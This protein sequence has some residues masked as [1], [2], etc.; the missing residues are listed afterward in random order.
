[1]AKRVGLGRTRSRSTDGPSEAASPGADMPVTDDV[2]GELQKSS[3][4]SSNPGRI[5]SSI[6]SPA[7]GLGGQ[8]ADAKV[9]GD[10][11][12]APSGAVWDLGEAS[13]TAGKLDLHS[14]GCK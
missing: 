6:W 11:T 4:T 14:A 12:E 9:L 8:G 2:D 1:M 5:R 3:A 7:F 13:G 10:P